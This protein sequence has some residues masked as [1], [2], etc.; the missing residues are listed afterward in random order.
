[1]QRLLDDA[2]LRD[3]A[4]HRARDVVA[5]GQGATQRNFDLLMPLIDAANGR[6]P[7]SGLGPTMPPAMSDLDLNA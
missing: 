1:L 5:E 2:E 6:L 3:D 4:G 7:A